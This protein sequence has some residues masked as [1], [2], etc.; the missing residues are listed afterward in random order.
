M[1]DSADTSSPRAEPQ[2]ADAAAGRPSILSRLVPRRTTRRKA[3][4]RRLA[5]ECGPTWV[6][7]IVCERAGGRLTVVRMADESFAPDAER[8]SVR[9]VLGVPGMAAIVALARDHALVG[10][11]ELPTDD[12]AEL[13][14]M[15]RI[16]LL[17]DFSVEGAETLCDFQ[18]SSSADGMTSIVGAAAT[19]VR[20]DEASARAGGPV[21]RISLRALGMLALIR[22][23]DTLRQGATLAVDVTRDAVECTLVRDGELQHSRGGAVAGATAEARAASVA[24][25]FR[26]LM[27]ALRGASA[28][29][30]SS[31]LA[32]DRVILAC[33]R[34]LAGLLSPQLAAIAGASAVRLDAHPRLSF[35]SPDLREQVCAGCLPL[36]GL[37]LEDEQ[38][39]ES[40]GNAVD[41]LHP[42]PQI[43]VAAL[44]RE[45]ALVVAGAVIVA[46]LG[47]WT[48]GAQSWRTL[49][50]RHDDLLAKARNAEPV[51]LGFK[52]DELKLR[53]IEAYRGLAPDWLAHFDALRRF[54]PD[55][56]SVVL[57]GLT[58]QLDGTEISYT[59][60]GK[61][62]S[63][64]E[65]RFV[66]DGEAR[67]RATADGLRDSLVQEKGY[68]VSSTGADARG[69]RRFPYPFAYTLR[70]ADL[71]PKQASAV[72]GASDAG[73]K[74]AGRS[75]ERPADQRSSGQNPTG[76][77]TP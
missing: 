30:P 8:P 76:A 38:A 19:R 11:I 4:A 47:G 56:S 55:P 50:S 10:R 59:D 54:A 52:R 57:D 37:L 61:M 51:R 28:G 45:R 32:V 53:H 3:E 43:D 63:A 27:A 13:R 29:S 17:R 12:E 1:V 7:A 58:A 2:G 6:R 14:S 68:T 21:A 24:V 73:Q 18:R 26:R 9:E 65:L 77:A 41:L 70:T 64:P 5:I 40:A 60:A 34:E 35:A 33:D 75:M 49:E 36:V 22:A 48:L 66:L 71:V 42:T 23:S 31:G 67:D 44:R 16:A 46:A 62:S 15:A 25:E 20:I 69:G 39:V 72:G 74:P